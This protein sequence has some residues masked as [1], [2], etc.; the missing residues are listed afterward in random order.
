MLQALYVV[1]IIALAGALCRVTRLAGALRLPRV[2]TLCIGGGLL[3]YLAGL[4]PGMIGFFTAPAA[5]GTLI[6]LSVATFL[7]AGRLRR[8]AVATAPGNASSVDP[9]GR[10]LWAGPWNPVTVL[11]CLATLVGMVPLLR[12]LRRTPGLMKFPGVKVTF[13][14]VSYHLPAFVDYAQHRT[15][16]YLGGP[17]SSYSYA[18]ELIYGYPILFWHTYWTLVPAA[19]YCTIFILSGIVLVAS[20]VASRF[21]AVARDGRV[22]AINPL[23]VA[24]AAVALYVPRFAEMADLSLGKNDLFLAACLLGAL[25]MFIEWSVGDDAIEDADE[26]MTMR[27][28]ALFV[29]GAASLGLAIGTKPTALPFVGLFMLLVAIVAYSR[30]PGAAGKPLRAAL[31]E[32]IAVGAGAALIGGFWYVRNLIKLHALFDPGNSRGFRMSL[33]HNWRDPR[34]YHLHPDSLLF[35]SAIAAALLLIAALALRAWRGRGRSRATRSTLDPALML[36]AFLLTALLVFPLTPFVLFRIYTW[37]IRL[38]IA[39]FASASIALAVVAGAVLAWGWGARR[40]L[41]TDTWTIQPSLLQGRRIPWH[42]LTTVLAFI[43]AAGAI[44]L[45]YRWQRHPPRGMPYYERIG[46]LP[47][48]NIYKWVQ[49]LPEPHRIYSVGLRPWGLYGS[50]WQNTLFY[51]LHSH[52]L[53]GHPPVH[54]SRNALF[55]DSWQDVVQEQIPTGR[56]RLLAVLQQ[57]HPDLLIVSVE[58]DDDSD[59]KEKP[60]EDWLRQQPW[61]KQVYNDPTATAYQVTDGWQALLPEY[62]TDGKRITPAW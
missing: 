47:A 20:R 17:F 45:P 15:L 55:Y 27:R 7:A 56:A 4:L 1:S 25:A 50:H 38:G 44:A 13:D 36:L 31:V 32:A 33:I 43:G 60:L 62:P 29:L 37:F 23:F 42:A 22:W 30:R 34:I 9:I 49:S 53:A 39:M 14:T 40:N 2:L 58:P 59:R 8:R 57:F 18:F 6:V 19:L 41:P 28:R 52:V 61:L 11:A 35:L 51:D 5:G 46:P 3:I 21:N 10:W 24:L 16:W 48:T 54:K 12:Y 26:W